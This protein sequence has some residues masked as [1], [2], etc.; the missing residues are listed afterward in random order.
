MNFQSGEVYSLVQGASE[1]IKSHTNLVAATNKQTDYVRECMKSAP[2][3]VQIEGYWGTRFHEGASSYDQIEE[4]C[5][6]G[7]AGLFQA[8]YALVQA[9]RCTNGLLAIARALAEPDD[10]LVGLDCKSGGYYATGGHA[11]LMGEIFHLETYGVCPDSFLLDYDLI[12][13]EI[14][15]SQPKI[16]FAGDTSYSRDWDWQEMRAIADEVGAYLVADISQTAGLIAARLLDNPAPHADVSIFATYKTFRG[17]PGCIILVNDEG[18]LKKI[19]RR[20][21]PGLQGSVVGT[22][23][24][25]LAAAIEEASAE[26]FRSYA[27]RIVKNSRQISNVLREEGHSI[28]T[29]G[30]DNHAFIV[31]IPETSNDDA[32]AAC[33]RLAQKGILTN[34]TPTPYDP[35]PL[36]RPSGVRIGTSFISNYDFGADEFDALARQIGRVIRTA[37]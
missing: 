31:K 10:T 14:S 4:Y 12:R 16:I 5:E 27:R 26:E 24:A 34:K 28:L 3:S 37:V 32:A 30:T 21:Y 36:H 1:Q 22:T 8:N 25:G 6:K 35:R 20:L 33:C 2:T 15:A 29:G 13:K 23:L 11:H 18:V 19:R 7:A 17:P 9:W